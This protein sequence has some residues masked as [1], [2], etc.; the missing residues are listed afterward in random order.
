MNKG[1]FRLVAFDEGGVAG[2]PENRRL[3][4]LVDS[5]G[6]LAIWGKDG[7]RRNIDAVLKAGVPCT[8]ECEWRPPNPVHAEKFGH[9]QW[10]REDLHLAVVG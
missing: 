4:C 1:T 8:V 9:T 5:G 7:A 10:V 2:S 3:V 6:K